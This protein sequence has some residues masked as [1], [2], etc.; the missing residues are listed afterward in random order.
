M[1]EFLNSDDNDL[2]GDDYVVERL[3]ESQCGGDLSLA[4]CIELDRLAKALMFTYAPYCEPCF[5]RDTLLSMDDWEIVESDVSTLGE[6]QVRFKLER[7][8][9]KGA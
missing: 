6:K 8:A 3:K 9:Q 1:D 7:S 5:S 4:R 2:D